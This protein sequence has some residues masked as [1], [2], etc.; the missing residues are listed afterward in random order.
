MPEDPSVRRK[1][2]KEWKKE[3]D[4]PMRRPWAYIGD[5]FFNLRATGSQ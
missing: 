2:E 3:E 1:K 4:M 5:V